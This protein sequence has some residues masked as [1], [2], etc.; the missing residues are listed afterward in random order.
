MCRRADP[1]ARPVVRRLPGDARRGADRRAAAARSCAPSTASRRSATFIREWFDYSERRM[2][3]AIAQLPAGELARR[4]DATTRIRAGARRRPADRQGRR[5]TPRRATIEV[6]LRDNPDSY[7]RRA[8][9][10]DAPAST[11]NAIDRRASTRIDPD[12]PHNAGSFRRHRRAS[13]ARTASPASRGFPHSCSMATTN[14]ADRLVVHDAGARSPSSATGFGLAEG[15]LGDG[16][17]LRGD[18]RRRTHGWTALRTSTRSSSARTGGPGAPVG[19]R[20]A[21]LLPAGGGGADVPRQHRGRRAE[22]PDPR[23]RQAPDLPDSEGAGRHRGA[24][25]SEVAYGPKDLPMIDRLHVRG[26]REPGA[27]GA[28]RRHRKS[29]RTAGSTIARATGSTSRWRRR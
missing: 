5:S 8:Q 1:R 16:H 22:V 27:R 24:L 20:L 14:I 17:R 9:R 29:R 25:G 13:C 6:D 4:A 2:A 26:P 10:V 21:D 12:V 18:L 11:N 7:R 23:A 19:R 15:A 3:Q 28:R